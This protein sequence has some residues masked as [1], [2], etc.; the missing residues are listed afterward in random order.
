MTVRLASNACALP[1]VCRAWQKWRR[2][3]SCGDPE[4][5]ACFLLTVWTVSCCGCRTPLLSRAVEWQL[6]PIGIIIKSHDPPRGIRFELERCHWSSDPTTMARLPARVVGEIQQWRSKSD[7]KLHIEWESD[8]SNSNEWLSSLL[9]PS[10]ALKLL[11]YAGGNRSAPKAKGAPAKRAYA[12]AITTG[13]W[14]ASGGLRHTATTRA[15]P[16]I[17]R[18]DTRPLRTR[19]LAA[20]RPLFAGGAAFDGRLGLH[21]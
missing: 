15:P 8:G 3:A 18:R 17:G 2:P 9:K 5:H 1:H 12:T 6:H 19:T 16:D 10:K 14:P 7:G 21:R 4:S 20:R 11:P 13:P